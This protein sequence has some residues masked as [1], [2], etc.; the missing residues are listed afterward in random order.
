MV[1]PTFSVLVSWLVLLEVYDF[2]CLSAGAGDWVPLAV[3]VGLALHLV[4]LVERGV[5]GARASLVVKQVRLHAVRRGH[6][7]ALQ[8]KIK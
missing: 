3:R 8:E 7:Q 4:A 5:A 1:I 6:S 2:I